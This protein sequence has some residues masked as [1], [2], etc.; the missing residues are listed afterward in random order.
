M[1]QLRQ[2]YPEFQARGAE[3]VVVGPEDAEAFRRYWAKEQLPFIGLPDPSLS[4]V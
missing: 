3:V 4:V 1:A 2:E